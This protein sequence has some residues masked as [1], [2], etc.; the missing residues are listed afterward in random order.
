MELLQLKYFK[1]VAE[2][3]RVVTAAESLFVSPPALS[4]S[5]SRLEKEL[6]M[7]L[8]D[9]ANNRIILNKQGKIFLSYVNQAL[10]CLDCAQAELRQSLLQQGHHVPI[11]VTTSNLWVDLITAFSQEY[12][13]FTLSCT[14]LK[15][16]QLMATGLQAIYPYLLAEEGDVI[17]AHAANLNSI[18]L[19]EDQPAVLVH[20]AHAFAKMKEVDIYTLLDENLLLPMHDQSLYERFVELFAFNN[21]SLPNAHSYSHFVC[22]SMVAE[23]LGISLTTMHAGQNGTGE[24]CCIP[25][26]NHHR[27]WRMRMFWHKT[28]VLNEDEETFMDFV[29]EIYH[30]S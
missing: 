19:F 2:A 5:I 8:F 14:T 4:A 9:R 3:G 16:S 25:V 6:G 11:A 29:R 26:I 10:S 23:N 27:P 18:V 20:P 1:A 17:P 30:I 7:R 15:I 12:P 21:V 22:R 24:L 28:R 13:H